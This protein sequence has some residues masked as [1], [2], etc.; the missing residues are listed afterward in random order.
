MLEQAVGT[1][2]DLE[3]VGLSAEGTVVVFPSVSGTDPSIGSPG[4]TVDDGTR[5]R[6]S[7]LG[8][9]TL[10]GDDQE[11]PRNEGQHQNSGQTGCHAAS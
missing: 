3:V 8:N 7:S 2:R 5:A 10:V 4:R 11:S 6:R 9:L 1:G